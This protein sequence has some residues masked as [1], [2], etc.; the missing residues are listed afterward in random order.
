MRLAIFLLGLGLATAAAQDAPG[1]APGAGERYEMRETDG[2]YM[3]L[4]RRTGTV[5]VCR[6]TNGGWTCTLAPDERKAL[7]S[8]IARL[9]ARVAELEKA[10]PQARRSFHLPE[11]REL[12]RAFDYLGRLMR[13]FVEALAM[14]RG[15]LER[16]G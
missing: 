1:S 12:R 11:K 10:A 6:R 14:I 15:R 7:E 2:G 16:S 13:D 4:D 3:R 8:E 5:S 9:Q